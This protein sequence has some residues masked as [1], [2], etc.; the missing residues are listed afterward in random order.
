[1]D[2]AKKQSVA[3]TVCHEVAHQWFGNITTMEWWDN[4]YLVRVFRDVPPCDL[5][6][7]LAERG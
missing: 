5:L 1:V 6:T 3:S 2:M 4:L 7:A